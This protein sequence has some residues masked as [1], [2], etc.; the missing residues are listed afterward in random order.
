MSV[1]L[2]TLYY[3]LSHKRPYAGQ[4]DEKIIKEVLDPVKGMKSD[5][6][7]NRYIHIGPDDVSTLFS[8]HTDT[9]HRNSGQQ[10]VLHHAKRGELYKDDKHP[11]GADDGAGM[12]L[13]L[14][15]IDEKIPG[16]Y[17]FHRGEE[18]GGLGSNHIARDAAW[19]LKPIKRAVAFDRRGKTDIITSQAGGKCASDEFAKEL[20]LQLNMG[21]KTARGSFT[22]T[23]NYI[24][25]V[26]ECTNI[27]VGYEREHSSSETLHLGYLQ[28]L[29]ERVCLV[30]WEGL[31]VVR[32][33]G[34][35][36]RYGWGNRD[37]FSYGQKIQTEILS[38]PMDFAETFGNAYYVPAPYEFDE[39]YYLLMTEPEVITQLLVDREIS[40]VEV[41]RAR[42]KLTGTS[43]VRN[44]C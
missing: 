27:S 17:V 40:P 23:A 38:E 26:D 44:I 37:A 35:T 11:L 3:I 7:G 28:S 36:G 22:D 14:N 18:C 30:D 34:D 29:L 33:P 13:M 4:S 24:H 9:V 43:K 6:F 8:C 10:T 41:D 21:H 39:L 42:A 5:L 16:L 12:W 32:K 1:D 31:P 25:L 2:N 19:M 15:M 20:S